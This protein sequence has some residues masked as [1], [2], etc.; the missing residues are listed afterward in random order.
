MRKV[1]KMVGNQENLGQPKK[2]QPIE[3]LLELVLCALRLQL[4]VKL[5]DL[6][7]SL[8]EDSRVSHMFK[9]QQSLWNDYYDDVSKVHIYLEDL[10]F[11]EEMVR[12]YQSRCTLQWV[13]RRDFLIQAQYS[14]KYHEI[15][16]RLKTLPFKI[17]R[18]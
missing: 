8:P 6:F 14:E 4:N 7:N 13:R 1:K 15:L 10:G 11:S 5:V 18:G 2:G 16:N 3:D 17:F 12:N 9:N